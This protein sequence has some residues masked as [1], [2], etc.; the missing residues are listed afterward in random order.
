M[1][2]ASGSSQ[3]RLIQDLI[4]LRKEQAFK[5]GDYVPTLSDN[6]VISFVREFDG[7]KG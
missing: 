5:V 4:K 6:E 2:N 7:E 1:A 3:I